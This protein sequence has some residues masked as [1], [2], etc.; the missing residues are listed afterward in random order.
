MNQ[1]LWTKMI[2]EERVDITWQSVSEQTFPIARI[3]VLSVVPQ[4]L[5]VPT[6]LPP[7]LPA[8]MNIVI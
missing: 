3:P 4:N 6:L 1:I 2:R 7:T 5:Q 8:S